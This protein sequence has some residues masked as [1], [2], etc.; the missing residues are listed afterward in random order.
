[1]RRVLAATWVLVVAATFGT[2]SAAGAGGSATVTLVTGDRVTLMPSDGEQ[3]N[4]VFDPAP[5]SEPTGFDVLR[6]GTHVHVV[7]DDV[8]SLV[9]EVLDP[10][11]F[12]VTALVE[13]GYDDRHRDDLPLIVRRG[14]GQRDASPLRSVSTLGSIRASAVE[15]DKD[16]AADLGDDLAAIGS[17]GRRSTAAA[18]GGVTR[19]WLDRKVEMAA[20]DGYLTQVRAPAA[21]SAGLNGAGVAVAVLDTG[22]DDGHPAL[23]GQVDA[24]TNFTT[25]ASPV[26][27]NGHGTH[28]A[29]LVAG[30]GAGSDGAR[31]GIATGAD[32]LSAKVLD[33]DG[34]GLQS[35]VI[36][37]MEWAAAEG[38]DVVNLSLGGPPAAT[39]DP[40]VQSLE[41]LTAQTGTLFVVAAGNRGGLGASPFTIETPGSAAAALTVGSVTATDSLA[42]SSSEGPTLGSYR[43][44]PDVA[45]PGVGILGARAGARD[46]DLYL[47]MSGTSQA[48]PIVAGAAALLIQQHPDWTWER[49]KA[50]IVGTAD[51]APFQTSW[52]H[53]GGRLDLD[54]ATHQNLTTDVATLGFGSLRHPD[55]APKTR[56]V[57]LSNDGP[58]PVSLVISDEQRDEAG[59]AAP[60]DALVASPASLTVPAGG[61]ASTTVTL[62]PGL[63]EDGLWQGGMSFSSDGTTLLRL[64]FGVYDEPERYELDV[65]M[66]DRNGDPYDPATGAEDP[67]G[68]TTIPI[69]N[70]DNGFFY[71][72]RPD[73]NGH[74]TA[75]VAPGTYSIFGRI[76]TPA[77]TGSRETFAIAGTAGL[78]VDA[79]TSYV[80]DARDAR[81]LDPPTVKGQRT[82]PQVA[83]GI[84]YSRHSE[85]RG[86]TEFG[87][88]D[89]QEVADGRVFITPTEPVRSGSFEATF[90]W[91]LAPSGSVTPTSPDAYDLLLNGPRFPDPLSPALSRR[92][93]ARLARV[94]TTFTPVGAPGEYRAGTVY[95]TV[96][97][98]VGFVYRTP[99]QVPGT[100]RV[101]MTA[102]PDVLWGHCLAVPANANRELCDDL[103]PYRPR[104]RVDDRFGASLHPE[105]FAARHSP[106]TMYIQ[107]GITDDAHKSA[108]DP[109]AVDSSR[110]TLFKDGEHVATQEAA[111]GFFPLPNEGGRFRVEQEWTLREAFSQSRRARTVWTFESAPPTDPSQGGSTTPPF[112]TLDYGAD[113]DHLGRAA[114]RRRLRL[115]L[116]A[117]HLTG[118][119]A[120][121]RIDAMRLWWSVDGG[122]SW[123]RSSTRRTGTASFRAA[124]PGNALQA[125]RDVSLRAAATDAAGN[126]VDQT[127]LGIVPVG[128]S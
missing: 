96:E 71:R 90:R 35:W 52:S 97:T 73:E 126:E 99:Q 81:R 66:I 78:E 98:G 109:S 121:D 38:A 104:E 42:L 7:P 106:S 105:P 22:V 48:T 89:P 57:T 65:R 29:S 41:N 76:I 2:A 31:Q 62:D 124:V 49:V 5:G 36:A 50:Q 110:L 101:L 55:D 20:L 95:Q 9:P 44:K 34:F 68:D 21:W 19:I 11:L 1:M 113:V 85:T 83:V 108:L 59:V 102:A 94:D 26:D 111:F 13:M 125:G 70:A 67:N 17:P 107:T 119:A 115:D 12:D 27:G 16:D 8:A 100:T 84:T 23:A 32:L 87:F 128:G 37:G 86:Y 28:V 33:D 18:L 43:L 74:A 127:V 114:P 40:L 4:V 91:R 103:H 77:G 63:L 30:T 75:R 45:A 58:E 24:Q 51:P 25:A 15:L 116:E 88:F 64:P 69:F 3:P 14:S 117:G 56:T 118:A 122:D 53:G 120:P 92:D 79:D 93:V 46:A 80:I 39:D 72:L 60:E 54:Q 82:E 61:T 47:P 112:M 10:A 123:H 6:D